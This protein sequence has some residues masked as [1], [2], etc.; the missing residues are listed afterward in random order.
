MLTTKQLAE[1]LKVD[2]KTVERWRKKG[3]GPKWIKLSDQVVR[4]DEKDVQE[5]LDKKKE[6]V[7]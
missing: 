6:K 7:G 3:T 2:R 4:Y 5:W 1:Q